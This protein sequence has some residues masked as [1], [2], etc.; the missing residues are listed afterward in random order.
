MNCFIASVCVGNETDLDNT[1]YEHMRIESIISNTFDTCFQFSVTPEHLKEV[2][3]CDVRL[4]VK[5]SMD[6]NLQRQVTHLSGGKHSLVFVFVFET[7]V[8]V[9]I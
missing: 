1:F 9:Q 6:R 7:Y 2:K 4:A 3:T 5:L 8:F